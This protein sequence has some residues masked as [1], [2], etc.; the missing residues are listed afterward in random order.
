[1]S[2]NK[3][4]KKLPARNEIPVEETWR[5]EDIFATDD[6]WEKEFEEVKKLIPG[7][8]R[9]KGKLGENAD[10]L[11]NALTFQD[12]LLERLG[13]LYTYAHMRYDQDTTNSFYQGMD[14]RIKNLYSQ[15]ASAL[16]FIVPEILSIEEQKVAA[17]LEEKEE[18]RL[19]KHALEEIN[20]QRPH[21]LSAEQEALLAEAAEVMNASSNTFGMLN[22]ADL[23]FP[24]IKDENG[25]EVEVTHGRYIR[26]L[27][28]SDRRV[29]KD[30]F[31]A[32][33]STYGKYRNT[34]ASTLSGTV[35]KDNFNARV[36]K[37]N[38]ARHAALAA[39]NI[40][41]SVYDNLVNTINDNLHLLHR[42]VK[43]R[44]KV[45]G[46]DKLHMYDLY[47]PLV[48]DVK[49]EITYEE[50]KEIIVKG[51]APLGEDY[52]NVLKEGFENRWVDVRE[53]KGKRSGAY[54]SGAYGTNPY[55]LMNWQDNVNNLFTLAHEFGHSVHSYFTRK[56]QPYPYGNYS[57][58]VAEVASTCNEA[59]LNDY[60]LKTIDDE[61]KRLYLLNH[62]L[63]GFRGTVFRQT[64][65]AEFEHLIHQ[66]A[67]NHE[68]LTADT[69][70]KEYYELNKKYFGLE[71]IE[72]DEEIGLE[73]ARIPHFYYN[74]YVY[75]YATGFSAATALS[76][77]I[78]E[79]GEPA[80]SRYIEFLKAGS[81]DY[82][83]EVLKKAGVDM[84]SP[85]PI[86][87][88]CKVFEEKLNEMESLLS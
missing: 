66:K 82:P 14:D 38:S 34:F 85:K 28:S 64:M 49:M 69:L 78:L 48:K 23:V 65:F 40:P 45:L 31:M 30:A 54:S 13:K 4:V 62:Y 29:R 24:S 77:Q 15:A 11:Y 19:Y 46:L 63:E 87:E 73:W 17:F 33:Y 58:F 53:N 1:M 26:F 37:Y 32:V 67:Q 50:A 20:L 41:E 5:L 51:L 35:K 6:E 9:Y 52:V 59:L 36:R 88:A 43:L 83:I 39:N 8:N 7:I 16:A 84:T 3:A 10:E 71:D 12:Q 18:L 80:V 42:Y 76:K 47:T 75:Q 21:V 25:E 27:E 81:S 2:N 61:K 70:T 68:P 86:E 55:I 74:Y 79:E 56:N 22:N 60:L 57:I 44:K 72:I